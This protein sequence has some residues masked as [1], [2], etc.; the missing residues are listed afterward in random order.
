MPV[1]KHPYPIV[2]FVDKA[3]NTLTALYTMLKLL[4]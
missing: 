2:D 3:R 1:L 4:T